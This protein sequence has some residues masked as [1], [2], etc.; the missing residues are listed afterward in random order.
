LNLSAV[1]AMTSSA[2]LAAVVPPAIASEDVLVYAAVPGFNFN[3]PGWK[4]L[5]SAGATTSG[6][7]A[8]TLLRFDLS[9][10][11]LGATEKATLN[12]Y[13]VDTAAAGFGVSPT[14]AKPVTTLVQQVTGTWSESTVT[15]ATRPTVNAEVIASTQL[16]GIN[17]WVSIDI[18]EAV[19]SWLDPSD[20]AANNGLL[21]T[22]A[23][24]VSNGGPVMG[25]LASRETAN[26]P[27]LQISPVPEPT[28]LA[29]IVGL[30]GAVLM[31]R[32]RRA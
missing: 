1:L 28:S 22:Q 15:W 3:G 17:R 2:A 14:E 12:L 8:Q 25:V 24:P 20:A 4:T 16:T 6:H 27:Y 13:V 21:L 19:R 31:G 10:I 29:A 30:G 11:T 9:G 23:A 18:T 32:R 26:Q 7:D 5:L